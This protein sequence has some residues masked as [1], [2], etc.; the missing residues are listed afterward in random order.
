MLTPKVSYIEVVHAGI[1]CSIQDGGRIG[2]LSEGIPMSGFMD[3]QMA[4]LANLLLDNN[5]NAAVIEWR[6]TPPKLKFSAPCQIVVTGI[7]I[8]IYLNSK[9][10]EAFR[11]IT[12]NEN[13]VLSLRLNKIK[14]YGYIA[15]KGGI[16]TEKILGSRSFYSNITKHSFLKKR[17]KLPFVPFIENTITKQFSK[18]NYYKKPSKVIFVDVFKGPEFELMPI[19]LQSGLCR[20]LFSINTQSNRMGFLLN[21]FIEGHTNSIISSPVLP[22][23]V[24]WT[25][26]GKLIIL[27]RDAQT[28]GG[29][30]RILQL[31]ENSISQLA[32][33]PTNGFIQ[34]VLVTSASVV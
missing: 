2:Y 11:V 7:G 32:K 16:Q 29:Y 19:S 28:V 23:T 10:K 34:F 13:D 8:D 25:P 24:Q 15:V 31:T 21:E 1:G 26:S 12:I 9:L 3:F 5:V 20:K 18:I 6:L 14:G 33:V 27:M 30:P 4:G 22:G 17:M